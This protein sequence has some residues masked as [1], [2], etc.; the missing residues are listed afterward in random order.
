MAKGLSIHIGLNHVDPH[1]YQGADGKPWDGALAACENDARD[2]QTLATSQGF[3]TQTLLTEQATAQNVIGAITQAAQE[4]QSGD[5]LFISYSGH[6]G[7]VPDLNGDEEDQMDETWCLY[8]RQL[9]DDE[10]YALWGR[11]APGVRIFMLSDSCHSGSVTRDPNFQM[12]MAS[13]GARLRLLPVAV[14]AGTFRA[15]KS[16][17]Q[18]IQSTCKAGDRA[19]IGASVILI[20]GCQDNQFS[21]DGDK[22]GLFTGTLLRVWKNGKFKSDLTLF[23]RRIV[24]RMPLYQSPNL[25]KVGAANPQFESQRPF[26]I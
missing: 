26:A 23:W 21:M 6:G 14:Q 5:L 19:A 10:L 8:D 13:S 20:S 12:I 9:I 1:H 11:F 4:L 18:E 24:E 17:Y 7:Q 15:H 16:L 22:N 2:M 25:F 3:V